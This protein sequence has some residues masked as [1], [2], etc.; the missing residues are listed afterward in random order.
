MTGHVLLCDFS[1]GSYMKLALGTP[2]L[3]PGEPSLYAINGRKDFDEA[4]TDFLSAHSQP[5]LIGAALASRGWELNGKIQL[6]EKGLTIDRDDLRQL[7]GVQRVNLV[8][9]FVA[10][11]LAI[12]R[13]RSDERVKVC[14]GDA[15]EEQVIA[16]LGP[17]FGLGQAALAPDG[18]GGWTA[19]PCEGGHSDLPVVTDQEW[20]VFKILQ[21][22]HGHVPRE[23]V[24]SFAGL[25]ELF[26]ALNQIHGSEARAT[27]A[28]EIMALANIG[29]P[30]AVETLSMCSAWLAAMASDVA[31]IL[32]ARGGIYLTGDL[33]DLMA[34]VFDDDAFCRRY[35]DK[36]RLSH[37]I[38]EIPVYRTQA[39]DLE[40][41]GL[42]TLFD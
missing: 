3:R 18:M 41:V 42:Q 31:L 16:V 39:K 2:G 7:A 4:I 21:K 32:G 11:A 12:P 28:E 24:I 8:N 13:L 17:H 40:I 10:R 34:E 1:F 22:R 30:L 38:E 26:K 14:G 27:T 19:M 25:V 9:N 23:F 20:E 29:D 36:G 6:P 33:M 5:R 37:F 35:V 15:M